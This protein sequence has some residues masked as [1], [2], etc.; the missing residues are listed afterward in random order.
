MTEFVLY[1]LAS[2]Q[3]GKI[4]PEDSDLATLNWCWLKG[5]SHKKSP[6]P[7]RKTVYMHRL[8]MERVLGRKLISTETVDHIN[9]DTLDNRR[10]NLRLAT[11]AENMRNQKRRKDNS[12]GYKGVCFHKQTKKWM[13]RVVIKGK[14]I[15]LGVFDTPELAYQA[16]CD[17]AR[18]IHGEFFRPE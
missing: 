13:A 10:S 6:R 7:E 1:Q 17:S 4:S 14:G 11:P 2:G 16:Y 5:Y 8:I 18:Q 3:N 12:S 9:G 15:Y